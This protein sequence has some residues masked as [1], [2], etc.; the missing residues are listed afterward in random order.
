M[1]SK[2]IKL[3]LAS[4]DVDAMSAVADGTIYF[5]VA[6]IVSFAAD[7]GDPATTVTF[8]NDPVAP[9]GFIPA[10]VMETPEQILTIIGGA[11]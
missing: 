2:F 6:H 11:A 8:I 9:S 1:T 5:N 7:A 10:C 4:V 3:T